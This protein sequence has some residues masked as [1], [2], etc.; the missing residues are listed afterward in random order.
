MGAL[1]AFCYRT[2]YHEK[3]V[4]IS[5]TKTNS[6]A[7][8]VIY[9]IVIFMDSG[10]F[11]ALVDAV[12][13]HDGSLVVKLD[14]RPAVV[15]LSVERYNELLGTSTFMTI[16]VTG[17]AGYIGSHTV[18][19]LLESG[20]RVVILDNFSTGRR[21]F[22]PKGADV[23]EGSVGDS[24]LLDKLFAD[25]KIDAVMHFAASLE[26]EESTQ[27]PIEYLQNN[28]INTGHLLEAMNRHSVKK[29]VFSSTCAVHGDSDIIPLPENAPLRPNNPYGASKL[30]AERFLKFYQQSLGFSVTIL[31]YFNVCGAHPDGDLGDTHINSHVIPIMLEAAAGKRDK[32]II[33]GN[34]YPTFDGTC[35][36]DYVHVMDVARAHLLALDKMQAETL[37]VYNVGTGR[38]VSV[39][40]L[41]RAATEVTNK[42]FQLE[43][44]AR[45]SGDMA[46]AEADTRKIK[47]ELGFE[48]LF[49]D[50]ENIIKT[51]W[52]RMMKENE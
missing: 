27:K 51:S 37:N 47:Q 4:R 18:R 35:V 50:L 8:A 29:I 48:P 7:E 6:L 22:I 19:L 12:K 52:N 39:E 13:A 3:K 43:I 1:F 20:H 32:F 42:M 15:V 33:N 38:G 25:H 40:A 23:I 46:A 9:F 31:R 2:C 49:S 34:D 14:G 24:A 36:R 11:S 21:E 10:F 45:R 5:Q 44:G 16:L 26:V 41:A 30:L 17:G 28:A